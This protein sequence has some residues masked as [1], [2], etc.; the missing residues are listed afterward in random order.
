MWRQWLIGS[1]VESVTSFVS[2]LFTSDYPCK[3]FWC[4]NFL[5][6]HH[7]LNWTSPKYMSS[8][9][10]AHSKFFSQFK[11]LVV[12]LKEC[13]LKVPGTAGCLCDSLPHK[14]SAFLVHINLHNAWG[15]L[16][17]ICLVLCL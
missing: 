9:V 1:S 10:S 7:Q 14:P 6:L 12:A 13:I 16:P 4:P 17:E 15:L 2:I 5:I 8:H 11:I 3:L